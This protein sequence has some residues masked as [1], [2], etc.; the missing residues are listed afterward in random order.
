MS[1][2]RCLDEFTHQAERACSQDIIVANIDPM[3]MHLST[4]H[5]GY[6]CTGCSYAVCKEH[7]NAE[8]AVCAR[9]GKI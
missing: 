3:Y 8:I 4:G 6:F 9:L 5:F 1:C 2:L 7:I